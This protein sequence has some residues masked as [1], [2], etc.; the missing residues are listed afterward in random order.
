M[1]QSITGQM[2]S[3][4]VSCHQPLKT[5]VAAQRIIDRIQSEHGNS[6]GI[7]NG[8]Q[9]FNL[10]DGEIA[11]PVEEITIAGNIKDMFLNLRAVGTDLDTRGSIHTG[12]WLVERMTIAGE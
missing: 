3:C 1:I 4:A 9:V 6:E 11:F 10:V 7:G 2:G 5:G 12:S 8:Q